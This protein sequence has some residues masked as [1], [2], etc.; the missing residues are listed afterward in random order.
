MARLPT[1]YQTALREAG[2]QLHERFEEVGRRTDEQ[3]LGGMFQKQGLT[4]VPV[5]E[6][7]RAEFFAEADKARAQIATR[8]VSSE[9]LARV[10]QLL[11]DH[12]AGRR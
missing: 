3:L 4:V 5:S 6:A 1:A 2:A 12:R 11:A 10:A 8:Y 9:L 7:F